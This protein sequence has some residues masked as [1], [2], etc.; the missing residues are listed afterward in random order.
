M[1]SR[2]RR[3]RKR[4][5]RYKKKKETGK[6]DKKV[7]KFIGNRVKIRKNCVNKTKSE[8]KRDEN[9]AFFNVY[10]INFRSLEHEI[11]LSRLLSCVSTKSVD[12]T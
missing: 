3:R 7:I 6:E 5:E 12:C 2:R 11:F 9:K 8:T 1:L 4:V 10:L